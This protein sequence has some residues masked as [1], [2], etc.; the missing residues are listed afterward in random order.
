MTL[1]IDIHSHVIP[2]AMVEAIAADPEGFAARVEGGGD[3]RRMRHDQGYVY[4][5]FAEFTDVKAK[6]AAMDRKGLDLSVVSPAPPMF[7][8]WAEMDLAARAARLVN[9]GIADMVG[10]APDRL[11]GMASVPLQYPELAMAELERVVAT[12]GFKAVEIGTTIEGV[13][14]ADPRFRPFLRKARDLGVLVFI[15]PYYVGS[16]AGLEN[17]Y[18]TNLAGNPFDTTVS[19]ANLIFSGALEELDGL[20]LLAAHGGGYLPYQIGRLVHGHKVRQE[21]RVNTT[22]SPKDL[23]KQIY[24]DTI[25]FDPQALRHLIDVV[26]APHVCLGTDAPFDMGD[27]TPLESLDQVPGLTAQERA[28]ITA[29]TAQALLGE[30]A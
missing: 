24:F 1:H 14:L 12:H 20:K 10:Q 17:Y 11:R 22:A 21:P 13:Q 27:E 15:H 2:P 9:D 7:Y 23:M 5:L 8:Y 19:L 29:G 28:A 4:P 25:V 30:P 6:L 16:K 3:N 18:L 26:G